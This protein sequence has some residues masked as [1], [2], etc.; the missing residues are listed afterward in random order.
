MSSL[1]LFLKYGGMSFWIVLIDEFYEKVLSDSDLQQFFQ[2][3]NQQRIKD[4]MLSLL[5]M[6][7]TGERFPDKALLIHHPLHIEEHHFTTFMS[8]Y[9]EV[10]EEMEVEPE[11]VESLTKVMHS[12]HDSIVAQKFS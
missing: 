7:F 1:A 12:Y 4:M 11:D 5:E 6:T 9:E 3:K 8:L 2:H 10:L